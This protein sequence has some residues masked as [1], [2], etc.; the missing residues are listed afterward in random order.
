MSL[1]RNPANIIF[2]VVTVPA[3]IAKL[4]SAPMML[5]KAAVALLWSLNCSRAAAYARPQAAT[6]RP[7][8]VQ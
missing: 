1:D 6:D 8:A 7:E 5:L 2:L 4:S 3:R